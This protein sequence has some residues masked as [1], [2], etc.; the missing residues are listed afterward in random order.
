MPAAKLAVKVTV[1]PVVIVNVLEQVSPVGHDPMNM[2]PSRSTSSA[3]WWVASVLDRVMETVSPWVTLIV[4]LG[5]VEAFQPVI[6]P[7]STIVRVAA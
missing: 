2:V 4:G 6:V 3:N 5:V 7:T 1:V